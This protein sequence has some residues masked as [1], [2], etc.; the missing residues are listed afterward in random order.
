MIRF[1]HLKRDHGY[2]GV[3]ETAAEKMISPHTAKRFFSSISIVRVWMF[4]KI[5]KQLFIWRLSIEK[6]KIIKI[7][8]DT[9][10]LDNNDAKVREGVESTYKKVKGFQPLQVFWGGPDGR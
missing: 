6:Q 1:D 8:I 7:G 2:A 9:R 3:I 10:V 5:L 4:R